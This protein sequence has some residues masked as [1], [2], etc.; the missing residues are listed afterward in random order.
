[1]HRGGERE[2]KAADRHANTEIPRA[3]ARTRAHR[4]TRSRPRPTQKE[5]NNKE[6]HIES[7][8]ASAFACVTRG[9]IS[10]NFAIK[11][12]HARFAKADKLALD[13]DVAP[14]ASVCCLS[15]T[16]LTSLASVVPVRVSVSDVGDEISANQ[17][18]ESGKVKASY[19][20]FEL[21]WPPRTRGTI[22]ARAE[23]DQI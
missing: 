9:G 15:A 4:L 21:L 23:P 2:Q 5:I 1:M 6:A 13:D 22:K 12:A 14:F 7:T 20:N 19:T 16:F 8:F 3:L 11:T 17:A 10:I 18:N